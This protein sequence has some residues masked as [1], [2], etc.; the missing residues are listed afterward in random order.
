MS[1]GRGP[2]RRAIDL[3][4]PCELRRPQDA[5]LPLLFAVIFLVPDGDEQSIVFGLVVL[6]GGVLHL[7]RPDDRARAGQALKA[8][9]PFW[10]LLAYFALSTT[11]TRTPMAASGVSFVI[12]AAST[13]AFVFVVALTTPLRAVMIERLVLIAVLGAG[14]SLLVHLTQDPVP[15]RLVAFGSLRNSV[16]TGWMFG[17][18]AILALHAAWHDGMKLCWPA[19]ALFLLVVFMTGSRSPIIAMLVACGLVLLPLRHDAAR[20]R[21]GVLVALLVVL[22]AGAAATLLAWDT[23]AEA[24]RRGSSHRLEIWSQT[25]DW[26]A[27]HPWLG[28]G[29]SARFLALWPQ[30]MGIVD[31]PQF[32]HPHQLMLS[33]LF[34]A[35]LVGL[36]LYVWTLG[37]PL[38]RAIRRRHMPGASLVLVLFLHF[39]LLGLVDMGSPLGAP[40]IAD[41]S[42]WLPYALLVGW[43]LRERGQAL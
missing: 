26:I 19:F 22:G 23:L 36:A 41:F 33:T 28:W 29:I 27:L 12:N 1:A 30:G 18:A 31:W 40:G 13:A 37:R 6:A 10:I 14:L 11:W 38:L 17:L 34:H 42:F 24:L 9:L 7:L 5:F 15:E 21:R 43:L 2:L 20:L 8:L 16:T 39:L 4:V 35:G 32:Y 3:A 25:I